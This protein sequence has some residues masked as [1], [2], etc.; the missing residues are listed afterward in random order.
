MK[1]VNSY[2]Y[3]C[4]DCRLHDIIDIYYEYSGKISFSMVDIL[5]LSDSEKLS[6]Y[7]SIAAQ[8]NQSGIAIRTWASRCEDDLVYEKLLH[9]S[10][11]V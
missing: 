7:F 6:E 1:K 11:L 2:V 4:S 9:F 10:T 5:A 3:W 8:N